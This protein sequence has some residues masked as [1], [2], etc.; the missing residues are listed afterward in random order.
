MKL[1]HILGT[2]HSLESIP[3]NPLL[4]PFKFYWHFN[5]PF[6]MRFIYQF[7]VK[8]ELTPPLGSTLDIFSP[9]S[10][11]PQRQ[12]P[13][14]GF[15]CLFCFVPYQ[16]ACRL[17]ESR[18]CVHFVFVIVDS[19]IVIFKYSEWMRGK[20]SIPAPEISVLSYTLLLCS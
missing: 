7:P 18:G 5:S 17:L 12:G 11:A 8:P 6:A 2:L 10:Y 3:L 14:P 1:F 15:F 4:P 9:I 16:P 20:I 13:T 19:H